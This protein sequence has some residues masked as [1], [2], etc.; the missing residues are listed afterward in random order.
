MLKVGVLLP[1]AIADVGEFLAEITALE[2]A[3]ADTIWVDDS[4]LDPWIVLGALAAVT[5]RVRLGCR[6][7][8]LQPWPPSRLGPA[9]ATLQTLSRSRTV[10]GIPGSRNPSSHI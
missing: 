9:A 10:V 5:R 7:T 4:A 6:L 2:A 8:S 3:G 1:A